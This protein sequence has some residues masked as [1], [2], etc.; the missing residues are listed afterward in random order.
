MCAEL[1]EPRSSR[2]SG[3]P[4]AKNQAHCP[5]PWPTGSRRAPPSRA[6]RPRKD[7][8]DRRA[9]RRACALPPTPRPGASARQARARS[10]RRSRA[11]Y[12]PDRSAAATCGNFA[13]AAASACDIAGRTISSPSETASPLAAAA[14]RARTSAPTTLPVIDDAEVAE[15]DPAHPAD[16]AIDER[17]RRN[18]RQRLAHQPLDRHAQRGRFRAGDRPQASRS[19]TMPVFRTLADGTVPVPL[20]ARK[21]TRYA[22]ASCGPA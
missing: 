14:D 22:V 11:R 13:H 17:V 21:A 6:P 15:L 1:R 10:R 9:P 16:G 7:K 5:D 3:A 18:R 4:S 19:V 20:S 2:P 8:A 12:L